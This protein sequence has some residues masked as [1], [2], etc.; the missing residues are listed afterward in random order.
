MSILYLRVL[1]GDQRQASRDPRQAGAASGA[2]AGTAWW[3]VPFLQK[4]RGREPAGMGRREEDSGQ[5]LCPGVVPHLLY[6]CELL[7]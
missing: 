2:Y 4:F 6:L 7:S 1:G 3:G 5:L